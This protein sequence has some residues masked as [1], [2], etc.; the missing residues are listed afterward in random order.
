MEW[1]IKLATDM[2][3]IRALAKWYRKQPNLIRKASATM[4]NNFAFGTKQE[5]FN[6]IC[7]R[8]TVR[9]PSFVKRQ[10]RVTKADLS[11]PIDN[12]RSI[13][14]SV[15]SARFDGWTEQELGTPTARNRYAT[16]ASRGGTEQGKIKGGSRL[17]QGMKAITIEDYAPKG[18]NENWGGFIAM[19]FR[20]KERGL[21]RINHGFYKLPSNLRQ[22]PGPT[23]SKKGGSTGSPLR[24]SLV[25]QQDLHKKQPKKIHWLRQARAIY[26]KKTDLNAMWADTLK[27][28]IK[29]P[30]KR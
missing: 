4:L 2:T 13:A 18:G 8:M 22:L 17:K 16:L 26:F 23:R 27:R 28:F 1:S 5:A 3:E 20:K 29:P 11:A 24:R 25:L 6:V 14:G 9:T 12:Q 19:L 7:A 15:A 21:I 30:P 10:L